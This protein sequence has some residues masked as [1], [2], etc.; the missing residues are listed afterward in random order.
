MPSMRVAA[1]EAA[2]VEI[3]CLFLVI[4]NS[5]ADLVNDGRFEATTSGGGEARGG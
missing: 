5:M 3:R 4:P 1:R 2:L